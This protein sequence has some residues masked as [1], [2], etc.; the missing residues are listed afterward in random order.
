MV[1]RPSDA[2]GIQEKRRVV[3][4]LKSSDLYKSTDGKGAVAVAF[5]PDSDVPPG[6]PVPRGAQPGAVLSLLS[7]FGKQGSRA[8]EHTIE[9]LLL[10]FLIDSYKTQP[11]KRRLLAEEAKKAK[12]KRKKEEKPKKNKKKKKKRKKKTDDD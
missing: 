5:R 8:D 11:E 2:L 9:N 4:L 6:A 1:E 7:H 12:S 3:S 10:N